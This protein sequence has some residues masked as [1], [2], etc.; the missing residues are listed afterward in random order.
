MNWPV[1]VAVCCLSVF[2]VAGQSNPR[3][4]AG[5]QA[6][7]VPLSPGTPLRERIQPGEDALII[8]S[9]RSRPLEVLPPS[10]TSMFEWSTANAS[11]VVVADIIDSSPVLAKAGDWI[12]STIEA[13]II[14]VLKPSNIWSPAAGGT[15]SFE[16]DGGE[17]LVEGTRVRAILPW[18][19]PFEVGHRYLLFVT[20]DPATKAALVTP[21][22]SYDIGG[23]RPLRLAS[24]KSSR[25][26]IEA[27]E[28]VEALGRVRAAAA[29]LR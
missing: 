1:T 14:E 23:Q 12:T 28:T 6:R 20:V 22:A 19:K 25:D 11:A 17:A 2:P 5:P 24:S 26:D 13:S 8:R 27:T 3:S 29:S 10:G 4:A 7:E 15:F 9:T 16:Q 18:A 21:L